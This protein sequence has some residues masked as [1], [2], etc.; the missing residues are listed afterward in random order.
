M[1]PLIEMQ[2][3][4][5]KRGGTCLSQQY[6]NSK[7]KL[8]WECSYGH[9]WFSTPFSIKIRKSWC[10]Q[11]AGNQ[12]FGIEAMQN[13]AQENEGK[14]LSISYNNCKTKLLWQ[15]KNGHRWYASAYS[16]KSK[17]RWCRKC[18]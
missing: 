9:R 8:L 15:C 14:C 18:L 13:L 11:C 16:V 4:A 5:K 17:K 1:K 2:L 3:I 10:P 12:P 7:D 6:V